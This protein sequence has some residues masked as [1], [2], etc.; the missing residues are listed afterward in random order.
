MSLFLSLL[1]IAGAAAPVLATMYLI[2]FDEKFVDLPAR[3][4]GTITLVVDDDRWVP[5]DV[6]SF[7]RERAPASRYF[8]RLRVGLNVI[9]LKP[10]NSN[11]E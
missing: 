4:D 9:R 8:R 7:A 5:G 3:N 11:E 10:V 1:L 6:P 2:I